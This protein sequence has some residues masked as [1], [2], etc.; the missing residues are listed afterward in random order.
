MRLELEVDLRPVRPGAEAKPVADKKARAEVLRRE[1]EERMLRRVA[2]A[3]VIEGRIAA[4][5]F[6][7]LADAARRCGVS[8]AR[9]SYVVGLG[10][11]IDTRR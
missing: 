10:G 3:R 2:L 9:V 4:G 11:M 8:R 1:R 6:V 5:G 7:D